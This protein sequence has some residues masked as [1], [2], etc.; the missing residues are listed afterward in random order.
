[1]ASGAQGSTEREQG[2]GVSYASILNPKSGSETRAVNK[3]NNKENIGD[4]VVRQ[5]SVPVKD[6]IASQSLTVTGKSYQIT[7]RKFNPQNKLERRYGN[8][9]SSE[10][11][12]RQPI[13]RKE[14]SVEHSREAPLG[15][16]QMNGNIGSDGEFQTVA[17]KSARRKE[18]IREQQREIRDRHRHRDHRLALRGHTRSNEPLYKERDR[19]DRSS[20]D[21]V[22][23]NKDVPR[24]RE[25]SEGDMDA[26]S[27]QPVKYVEAPIPTVNPWNKS[28]NAAMA[29]P[30]A[31]PKTVTVVPTGA[32]APA[33]E[34]Q[35]EQETRVL[36]PQ[37]QQPQVH[38][39]ELAIVGKCSYIMG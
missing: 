36:Q 34:K 32:V 17:P 38:Q 11:E 25:E 5:Q 29:V 1:M 21:Q 23:G 3:D 13:A 30:M 16:E 14:G 7:G 20:T 31:V 10:T 28:K 4:Q 8:E 6:R 2:P 24:D 33:A 9:L 22:V 35:T 18:K 19:G 26:Q 37:Q 12:R 15:N 39:Q 27:T